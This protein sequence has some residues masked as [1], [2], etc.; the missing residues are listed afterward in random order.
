[1]LDTVDAALRKIA[2]QAEDAE[3]LEV[4]ADASPLDF[5]YAVYR[6]SRQPMTRR[7]KA[8]CEAAQYVH[9][10]YKA[11]A[12]VIAGGSFAQRLE[13]AIARS[14]PKVIEHEPKPAKELPP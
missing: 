2:E 12:M 11:T 13:A 14:S 5:L 1:M 4:S 7:L 6:D 10:T 3:R 9:P 8:A